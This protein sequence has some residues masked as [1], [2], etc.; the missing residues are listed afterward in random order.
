MARVW[1]VV[2]MVRR[3]HQD[4]RHTDME[5]RPQSAATAEAA[6]CSSM[7]AATHGVATRRM[8]QS[9]CCMHSPKYTG[10]ATSVGF[11]FSAYIAGNLVLAKDQP[12]SHKCH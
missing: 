5:L 9:L 12:G 3:H 10:V 1:P 8:W 7:R 4:H 11:A 6:T 2:V